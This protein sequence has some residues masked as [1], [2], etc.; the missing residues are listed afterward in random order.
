MEIHKD[1][2]DIKVVCDDAEV[3]FWI[4]YNEANVLLKRSHGVILGNHFRYDGLSLKK[5]GRGRMR[6]EEKVFEILDNIE[7]YLRKQGYS[8]TSL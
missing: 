8:I 4:Q 7:Q 2:Q 6:H 5:Y 1:G 3:H